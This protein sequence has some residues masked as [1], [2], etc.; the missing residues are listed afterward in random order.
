[1]QVLMSFDE[2]FE[3]EFP[4]LAALQKKIWNLAGVKEYLSSDRFKERPINYYPY[5]K[6]Y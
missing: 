1:M 2:S 4:R 6:W 5:A 3:K